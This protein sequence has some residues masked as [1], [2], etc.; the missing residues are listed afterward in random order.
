LIC[1]ISEEAYV[2][3]ELAISFNTCSPMMIP[4]ELKHI[5]VSVW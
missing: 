5:R 3:N 2:L 4:C 1:S